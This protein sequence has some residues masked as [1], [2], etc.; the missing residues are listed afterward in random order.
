[1]AVLIMACG[2]LTGL[3]EAA[4]LRRRAKELSVFLDAVLSVKQAA[5]YTAGDLAALIGLCAE[6]EFLAGINHSGDIRSA[7]ENAADS[8]F[9]CASDRLLATEFVSDFGKTDLNGLIS[10]I[11]RYENKVEKRLSVAE[12][13]VRSKCKLYV[14]LGFF[15]GTAA[16]LLLI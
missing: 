7:W 1:M 3:V 8:F 10:Y 13:A 15:A 5:M 9:S 12:E 2:L 11:N 14:V 4:K 16:A 6:N